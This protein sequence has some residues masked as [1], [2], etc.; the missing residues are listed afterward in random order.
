MPC[1]TVVVGASC[2]PQ[3]AKRSLRRY[4]AR[5]NVARD[6]TQRRAASVDRTAGAVLYYVGQG[7][8]G[9]VR[10]P[11]RSSERVMRFHMTDVA[12]NASV[13]Q[14][15][16]AERMAK[17]ED[18][19]TA[20]A[21]LDKAM[22][23]TYKGRGRL[24]GNL[25]EIN[26]VKARLGLPLV[27]KP[28]PKAAAAAPVV[29]GQAGT[30][31]LLA[32]LGLIPQPVAQGQNVPIQ[33]LSPAASPVAAPAIDPRL[34]AMVAAGVPAA[35]AASLLAATPVQGQTVAP[36]AP[37][38]QGTP[39]AVQG[40]AAS[41]PAPQGQVKLAYTTIAGFSKGPKGRVYLSEARTP[42]G[43]RI[44]GIRNAALVPAVSKKNVPVP[45][46]YVLAREG[47]QCWVVTPSGMT[48]SEDMFH[49]IA[50]HLGYRK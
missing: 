37:V 6:A 8:Q 13:L 3:G 24:P 20:C 11:P 38:A 25:D 10:F 21:F 36:L 43:K 42:E 16:V 19:A 15:I 18:Q 41:I 50:T 49:A 40:A 23:Y 33:G 29:Q 17:G 32:S 5:Y 14:G 47:N 44:L 12:Q 48:L 27:P 35:L 28:A 45:A 2:E 4:R 34:A 39:V 22:T 7:G 1:Y 9:M 30:M 46:Q 26:A 31:A